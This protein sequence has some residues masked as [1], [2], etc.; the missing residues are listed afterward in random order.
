VR[1]R[2]EVVL[3]KWIEKLMQ[4]DN[5]YKNDDVIEI[6][7]DNYINN[8][9]ADFG[10]LRLYINNIGYERER[11]KN[12]INEIGKNNRLLTREE[13]RLLNLNGYQ[14]REDIFENQTD[15]LGDSMN[16]LYYDFIVQAMDEDHY[17]GFEIDQN[18]RYM[19]G[20]LIVTHNSN[21]KSKIEELFVS[22]FG[23]YTIKFPITL[24]TG[25]RAQSN[26][27]TPEIAQSKGKRFG[28][29]EEPGQN[30]KINAGLLKEFTGGDKLKARALHKEPIEFKPQFKL[31]LLCNDLPEVPPNDSGTWRRMEVIE[32]KSRFCDN[33]K[34]ENEFPID[35]YLSDKLKNWKELFMAL[36]IDVYYKDYKK[37]GL[38]VPDEI[39]K[40]TKEYQKACDMYIEFFNEYIEETNDK[41]DTVDIGNLYELF[42]PWYT[43]Y[44]NT[45]KVINRGDFKKNLI[46]RYGKIKIVN[47]K[48]LNCCKIKKLEEDNNEIELSNV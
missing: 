32:F 48:D 20:N 7:V 31:V 42:K 4:D 3:N 44:M 39:I 13:Q 25:K 1:C 26:S 36:L 6:T 12:I 5:V 22:A 17:Y 28:Y 15:L 30:E 43:D 40:Y 35:K 34:E 18:N 41:K 24:L 16:A 47:G 23:E 38:F 10:K 45:N 37:S 14:F 29:F 19:M 21:G 9:F 8:G 11:V 33:P 46:K 2:K 27:A